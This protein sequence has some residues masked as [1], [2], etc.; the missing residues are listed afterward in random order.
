VRFEV[1]SVRFVSF[2]ILFFTLYT[3]D[4]CALTIILPLLSLIDMIYCTAYAKVTPASVQ[5]V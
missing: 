4:A 2:S 1:Q 5:G 3:V